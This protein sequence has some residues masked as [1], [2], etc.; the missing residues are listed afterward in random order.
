[1]C[2]ANGLFHLESY[3]G[4]CTLEDLIFGL[5]VSNVMD[6][7]QMNNTVKIMISNTLEQVSL[8]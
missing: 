6:T 7:S 1:M 2:A 5:C 4:E 3:D 8:V